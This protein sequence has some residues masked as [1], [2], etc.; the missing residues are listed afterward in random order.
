M[1]PGV[2]PRLFFRYSGF[3]S[4]NRY[5]SII[6]IFHGQHESPP[7]SAVAALFALFVFAYL[8]QLSDPTSPANFSRK[9]V[10]MNT[11]P[12]QLYNNQPYDNQPYNNQPYNNQPNQPYEYPVNGPRVPSY[13]ESIP[14]AYVSGDSKLGD[15]FGDRKDDQWS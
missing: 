14:P 8:R 2:W 11:F 4:G 5:V 1:Q 13:P 15:G 12:P 10:H 9:P 7:F 6:T 3:T